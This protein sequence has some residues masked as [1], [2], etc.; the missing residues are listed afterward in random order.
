MNAQHALNWTEQGLVPDSVIRHG[1][2]RLL[3]QRLAEIHSADCEASTDIKHRFIDAMK[4][5][6]IALLTDKANEQHYEVPAALYL[7][8]MKLD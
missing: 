7:A 6:H 8:I 3:K 1:I 2:R 5:S 4:L